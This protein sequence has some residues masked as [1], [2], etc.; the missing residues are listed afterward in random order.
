MAKGRIQRRKADTSR[1]FGVLFSL[2]GLVCV[3]VAAAAMSLTCIAGGCM[4]ASHI[5]PV[6]AACGVAFLG[7]TLWLRRGQR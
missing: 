2:I 1:M 7:A 5:D 4:K 6:S 3:I